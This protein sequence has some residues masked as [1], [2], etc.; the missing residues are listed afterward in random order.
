MDIKERARGTVAAWCE[1]AER[2][3]E[4]VLRKLSAEI[5]TID[6]V[7]HDLDSLFAWVS[8]IT[9]D[10]QITPLY[11]I[12]DAKVLN[13][14]KRAQVG[15]VWET[16]FHHTSELHLT[17]VSDGDTGWLVEC[18]ESRGRTA[19]EVGLPGQ[20]QPFLELADCWI[21]ATVKWIGRTLIENPPN[22]TEYRSKAL[23]RHAVSALDEI[24]HMR[25]AAYIQQISRFLQIQISSAIDQ[26]RSEVVESGATVWKLY[27]HGWIVKTQNHCWG[28]DICRGYGSVQM[29]AEQIDDVIGEIEA[30][31]ISHWH[32]DHADII[33]LRAALANGI[34]VYTAPPM[35]EVRIPDDIASHEY[36]HILSIDEWALPGPTG[37]T[38]S[39][40]E[41]RALPGHQDYRPNAMFLVSADE[42]TVLQS[43]DQY[44]LDDREWIDRLGDEYRVDLL[45]T[46]MAELQRIAQGVRPRAV[47]PGHE[48]ELGHLFEHR[49][50]YDQAYERLR[51]VP[52]IPSEVLAWGE[53][54]HVDG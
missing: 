26:I 10:P 52:E 51:S 34:N 5:C 7:E 42:F 14:A 6:G 15:P 29:T 8:R 17:L 19:I 28:H 40:I 43:G 49:E 50:P 53:R 23:R 30:L 20:G 31:F 3:D 44:N 13:T 38:P 32:R 39:G 37:T 22:P 2:C 45:L 33:V 35:A 47:I 48:N 46:W 16:T 27:D 21:D 1:A 25:S 11:S 36:M 54:L 24:L 18:I 4:T 12:D 9:S 41:W